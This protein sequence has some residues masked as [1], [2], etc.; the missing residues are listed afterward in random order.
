MRGRVG[1][2]RM[3]FRAHLDGALGLNG[4]AIGGGGGEGEIGLAAQLRGQLV[5]DLARVA[6][7]R[8]LADKVLV[9]AAIILGGDLRGNRQVKN[10]SEANGATQVRR[11]R[12]R[13]VLEGAACRRVAPQHLERLAP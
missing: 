2:V 5:L 10:S 7:E 11:A 1:R 4:G 3:G 8:D 6:G 9:L 12:V 13:L